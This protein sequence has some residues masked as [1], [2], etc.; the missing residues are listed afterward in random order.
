MDLG[1]VKSMIVD[2]FPLE[3]NL[4]DRLLRR[5]MPLIDQKVLVITGKGKAKDD[6][7]VYHLVMC[8]IIATLSFHPPCTGVARSLS[9]WGVS[10][11]RPISLARGVYAGYCRRR[12]HQTL[13]G[14]SC[15]KN[16]I[17]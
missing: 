4:S 3:E 14:P 9:V 7:K 1:V 8:L 2:L 6:P 17:I 10:R 11:S 15:D 16:P 13:A 5:N 12:G